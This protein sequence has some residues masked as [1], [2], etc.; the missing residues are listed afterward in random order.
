ME[1]TPPPLPVAP[2][3]PEFA[4][5]KLGNEALGRY[6]APTSSSPLSRVT[7]LAL[8]LLDRDAW[9]TEQPRHNPTVLSDPRS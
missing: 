5:I 9:Q 8:Q 3:A 1:A 6:E 2:R 7:T 4:N